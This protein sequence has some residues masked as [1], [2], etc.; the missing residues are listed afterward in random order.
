MPLLLVLPVVGLAAA[1][2]WRRR[3][4]NDISSTTY[5]FEGVE[6]DLSS[7][8][9]NTIDD[10]P[11]LFTS[12]PAM[13]CRAPDGPSALPYS[14]IVDNTEGIGAFHDIDFPP[15]CRLVADFGGGS[16]DSARRYMERRYPG[17]RLL[18]LDPF[19][20]P[21]Q[22]NEA[23]QEAIVAAGGVDCATCMSVLNVV[24]YRRERLRLLR[25][26]RSAMRPGALAYF[27]VWAGAWPVRGTGVATTDRERKAY[28]ANR[29]ASGF[30]DEVRGVFE[31]AYA[32]NNLNLIVARKAL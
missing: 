12:P 16:S 7:A 32:D 8:S 6:Y 4:R 18:V 29:W 1:A 3:Q 13:A 24:P 27:K 20:R 19:N 23:A 11:D 21:R 2:V 9:T 31:E 14:N 17:L 10:D 30:L 28:Q 26:M 25:V 15:G 5:W 22:H